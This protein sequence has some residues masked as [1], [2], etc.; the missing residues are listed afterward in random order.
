MTRE[1]IRVLAISSGGG[2]W[3]ELIRVR[4]ALAGCRVTWATVNAG[5]RHDVK[6]EEF[7]V[8]PDATRWNKLRL[9]WLAASV[10][11]LLLRVRPHV[12]L[13]TGAAPGYIALR[14]AKLLGA[15]TIWLDSF[16]NIEEL[17]LS[18]R[19]AGRC[20]DLWLTQWPELA[21]PEGPHC[22]GAVF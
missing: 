7:A 19:M 20:A 10:L 21:R 6:G 14:F 1:P 18:G 16:A 15:R 13:S 12:V 22:R 3:L 4:D 5:Y 8:I 11:V 9:L 2:H 17:S